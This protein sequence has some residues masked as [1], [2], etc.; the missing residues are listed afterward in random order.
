MYFP[1]LGTQNV[2]LKDRLV[3]KYMYVSSRNHSHYHSIV[4]RVT[5]TEYV[6]IQD[7]TDEDVNAEG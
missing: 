1:N 7:L 3:V 2:L 6:K 4:V 5:V